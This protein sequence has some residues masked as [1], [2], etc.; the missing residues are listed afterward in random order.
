[1]VKKKL[2]GENITRKI[3]ELTTTYQSEQMIGHLPQ[4][5]TLKANQKLNNI[6][7]KKKQTLTFKMKITKQ[8]TQQIPRPV[9][10]YLPASLHLLLSFSFQHLG[11]VSAYF[12]W[13]QDASSNKMSRLSLQNHAAMLE[14]R[15]ERQARFQVPQGPAGQQLVRV[16]VTTQP[17]SI[18][19]FTLSATERQ[20]RV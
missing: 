6:T 12:Q 17:A 16:G 18:L 15:A 10:L 1:M 13:I 19:Q 14:H 9:F 4:T 3:S 8:T 20:Q 11:G 7:N 2:I 5:I